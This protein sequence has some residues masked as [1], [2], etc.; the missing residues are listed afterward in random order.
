MS[1]RTESGRS[2]V[3]NWKVLTRFPG[4]GLSLLEIRPET[5]RTHQIRVH[6]SSAGMPIAGDPVY[7]RVRGKVRGHG[8][9][10]E[11][12]RPALHAARLA[13]THPRS[14]ERLDFSAS[15]P[16]DLAAFELAVAA[17]G[18]GGVPG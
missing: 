13:F 2:A 3:T 1:I 7:G 4:A 12:E 16:E 18:S 8:F 11:L 9:R 14:G 5:G 6:L 10:I 15:F 17:F